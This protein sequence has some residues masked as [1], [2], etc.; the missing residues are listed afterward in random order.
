M[1]KKSYGDFNELI[2]AFHDSGDFA[3]VYSCNG[4]DW[5]FIF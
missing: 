2:I 3:I 4:W 1:I 5:E